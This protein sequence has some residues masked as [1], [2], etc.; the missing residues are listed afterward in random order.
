MIRR[1]ILRR[2]LVPSSRF[3]FTHR[4]STLAYAAPF[5]AC[6][7]AVPAR[8]PSFVTFFS[9]K[10]IGTGTCAAPANPCRTFH[11]AMVQ[12]NPG[13]EI[14]ALDPANYCGVIVTELISISGVEG[15]GID[16]AG[17]PVAIT[18]DAGAND[19]VNLSHLVIDGLGIAQAAILLNSGGLLTI[20]DCVVRNFT[21]KGIVLEQT[22]NTKFLIGD[23]LMS[24]NSGNAI[25]VLPQG[26]GSA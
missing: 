1:Q 7:G 6:L 17:G 11:F 20:T 8:A 5:Q 24:D 26:T 25:E 10:G 13:G 23:T 2:K 21:N 12:S 18:I 15:A 19:V 3:P 14:E 9:G 4:G 22:S 16:R